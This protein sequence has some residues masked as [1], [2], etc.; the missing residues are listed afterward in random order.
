MDIKTFTIVSVSLLGLAGCEAS[1]KDEKI[2]ALTAQVEALNEVQKTVLNEVQREVP[3]QGPRSLRP[4]G[5]RRSPCPEPVHQGDQHR[6]QAVLPAGGLQEGDP[7]A[8]YRRLHGG[9]VCGSLG[10]R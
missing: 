9:Q 6:L 10:W 4:P 5:R 7:D 3:T 2:A 8:S 1:S